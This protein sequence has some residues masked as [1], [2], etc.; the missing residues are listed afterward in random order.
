MVFTIID[1]NWLLTTVGLAGY[2]FWNV[3]MIALMIL[4]YKQSKK[5]HHENQQSMARTA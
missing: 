4:I 3:L 5:I 2:F 1:V